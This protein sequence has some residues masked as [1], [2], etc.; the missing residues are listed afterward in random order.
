MDIW[1]FSAYQ[2]SIT[3]EFIYGTIEKRSLQVF[4]MKR[5]MSKSYSA[6]GLLDVFQYCKQ[7]IPHHLSRWY[8]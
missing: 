7:M 3:P 6:N 8:M 5:A 4:C 1:N 2:M